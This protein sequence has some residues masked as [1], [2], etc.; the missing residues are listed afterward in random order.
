[1]C[2]CRSPFGNWKAVLKPLISILIPVYNSEHWVA[3]SLRS[4]IDQTWE[5]KE[6][7]VVNDGST[8]QTLAVLRQFESDVVRVVTQKN[9]GAAAARNRAFS[10]S[11]GR[12]IQWLDADDV[13]APDKIV[14]QMQVLEQ[15]GGDE[16][17]LL[18]GPW[19]K[20][21]YRQQRAEFVPNAL[22]S[23]LS[24]TEWMVRKMEQNLYMQTATWLVS[25]EMTTMAG[26]WDTSLLGDDDG[27]YFCRVM[28]ASTGI[29]FVPEAKVYYRASGSHSLSY[30]GRSEAKITAHWR[31]MELHI[32]YLRSLD[33]SER[34]RQACVQ[35]LQ[36]W[37]I[38]FYPER[39]EIVTK[40]Q[41]LANELGREL[42]VPELSWKYAWLQPVFG[43]NV[44]KHASLTMP[45][46]RWSIQRRW[47]KALH[48][49]RVGHAD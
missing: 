3:E 35:Y 27:E 22:W 26:P 24:P 25:R 37:L 4:A 15:C 9:Q 6:I 8:D 43:W 20:F 41:S 32:G 33:D 1:M 16:R 42:R 14:R 39:P 38:L 36:N 17:L 12:Y 2:I 18:S 47:D 48:Q 11:R 45:A 44:A 34:V 21:L 46:L 13:L 30:I 28:M 7:I 19:G 10:E 23:D 40:A 31:S 5:P 49:S 29:R